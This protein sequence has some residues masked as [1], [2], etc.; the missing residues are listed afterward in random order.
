MR[1]LLSLEDLRKDD[2]LKLIEKALYIKKNTEKFSKAMYENS[3][4]MIFEQPSL[5]TILS[6]E[7]AMTQMGG[8]AINYYSALSPWGAGKESIED[9]GHV[10]SRYVNIAIARIAEHEE[11]IKLAENSAV[12]IIN[13]LSNREHP[14]QVL[15]D[16]LTIM[17]KRKT[18]TNLQLTYIG[19]ANNNVTYSLMYACKKLGIE[20]HIACPPNKEFMPDKESVTKTGSIVFNNPTEAAKN[21]DIIYTDSWMSYH[22]SKSQK[23]RRIKIL[24]PY[25][26]TSEIMKN[27][28]KDAV[29]MHCL[30][31]L[32]EQEVTKDVI[33]GKQSIIFD[34]AENRLHIQKSIILWCLDK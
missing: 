12:P 31:A 8:H 34:Q 11:I 28:K 27:A 9:V 22:I 18:L 26:V 16:M 1:H 7:T 30:P 3:M 17:E 23:N 14:C 20:M 25:Q 15:G 2:M 32:R 4:L 6:F 10:I 21:S 29:F 5:R 13:A 19:D 33:D 24:K